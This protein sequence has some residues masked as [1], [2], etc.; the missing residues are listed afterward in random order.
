MEKA[1]RV[2]ENIDKK[3]SF[4]ITRVSQRCFNYLIKQFLH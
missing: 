4:R 1:L 2:E 3:I